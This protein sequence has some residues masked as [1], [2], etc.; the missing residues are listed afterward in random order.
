LA[1]LWASSSPANPK[2]KTLQLVREPLWIRPGEPKET[3]YLGQIDQKKNPEQIGDGY[4]GGYNLKI[5]PLRGPR[6]GEAVG[7]SVPAVLDIFCKG[8]QLSAKQSS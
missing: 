1:F 4:V 7:R 6:V 5:S 2:T 8:P 3:K